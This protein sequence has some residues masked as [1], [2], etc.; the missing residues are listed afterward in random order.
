MRGVLSFVSFEKSVIKS[1]Q[2]PVRENDCVLR[3][4]ILMFRLCSNYTFGIIIQK[5]FKIQKFLDLFPKTSF[6]MTFFGL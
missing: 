3:L 4:I 6:F 1:D 5:V 2:N